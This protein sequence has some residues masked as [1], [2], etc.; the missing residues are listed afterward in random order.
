MKK[1][2]VILMLSS[3]FAC[4]PKQGN[5]EK[6]EEKIIKSET[7][8]AIDNPNF[9][10]LVG[11]W[12]RL[13][14]DAQKETFENWV[15]KTDSQF[16]GH[17]FVMAGSD[18]VWQERMELSKSDSIWVLKVETPGNDDL[19][20][21]TLTEHNSHSFIVENPAHDFPKK[22][23]YWKDNEALKALVSGGENEISFEFEKLK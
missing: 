11:N 7:L 9:D 8:Q 2:V 17:G 18:T 13:S 20:S 10:W 15:K 23:K 6:S 1:I 5:D 16:L 21:F 3:V 4:S 14:E 19:V 12:K 22:I